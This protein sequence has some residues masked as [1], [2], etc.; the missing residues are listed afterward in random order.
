VLG[1]GRHDRRVL[2]EQHQHE[3]IFTSA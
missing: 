2:R 1:D 3:C